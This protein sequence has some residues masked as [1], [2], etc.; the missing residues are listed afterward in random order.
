MDTPNKKIVY[1]YGVFDLFHSGHVELLKEA[2]A[3]GDKLIVGIF[4]D[5][6]AEGFKRRPV[7]S[8][9]QR[10][11][12]VASNKFVD[13]V[14]TQDT[15]EPDANIARIRPAILAKGPGAGWGEGE[16]T[17]GE[18]AIR[19]VSGTVVKLNYHPGVSTSEIISKIKAG[20]L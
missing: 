18:D 5:E 1:T 3:L 17:P 7:I 15:L 16:K 12:V 6:V 13:E 19:A 20:D 2:R 4:T 9:E 8:F 14:V 11:T 10:K